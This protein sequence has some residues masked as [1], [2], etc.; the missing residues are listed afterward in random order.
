MITKPSVGLTKPKSFE[1]KLP[2]IARD[3][4]NNT[5]NLDENTLK[6]FRHFFR[7]QIRVSTRRFCKFL[8]VSQNLTIDAGKT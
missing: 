1:E 7:R 5:Y 3:I 2:D 8:T 4:V 6:H